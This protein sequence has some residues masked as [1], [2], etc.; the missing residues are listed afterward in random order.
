MWGFGTADA[1]L[2]GSPMLAGLGADIGEGAYDFFTDNRFEEALGLQNHAAKMQALQMSTQQ[3]QI[4]SVQQSLRR[5]SQTNPHVARELISGLRLPNGA[6]VFGGEPRVDLMAA[7]GAALSSG[8][9]SPQPD[10]VLGMI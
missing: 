4:R 6:N 8:D 9:L 3:N 1:V 7:A 10:P 2:F 5:L